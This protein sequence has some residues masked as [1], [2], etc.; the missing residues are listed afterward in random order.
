MQVKPYIITTLLRMIR[1]FFPIFTWFSLQ[2]LQMFSWVAIRGHR[3]AT[4]LLGSVQQPPGS[5]K[6]W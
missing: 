6:S 2:N 3:A 5:G 1:P 4:P